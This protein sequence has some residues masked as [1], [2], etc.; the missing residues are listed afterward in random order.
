MTIGKKMEAA[1]NEQIGKEM[2]SANIYMAMATKF[3]EMGL[4][5]FSAFLY[6]HAGEENG[7]AMRFVKYLLDASGS[8]AISAIPAPTGIS[9]SGTAMIKAALAHEKVITAS[10]NNLAKIA[11]KEDDLAALNML[12]WFIAE[13]VE[14]E[15]TFEQILKMCEQAG[16]DK[17]FLVQGLIAKTDG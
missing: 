16:D 9:E 8:P 7:H 11:Q 17:L 5:G 15:A 4:P 10:I 6:K 2:H 3:D 1:I 14:E 13:Q 12:Q